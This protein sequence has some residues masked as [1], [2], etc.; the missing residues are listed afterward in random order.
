[1]ECY[2]GINI[3][4]MQDYIASNCFTFAYSKSQ[5]FRSNKPY[6]KLTL[7]VIGENNLM[8]TKHDYRSRAT[9]TKSVIICKHIYNKT[10]TS[11][12]TSILSLS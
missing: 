3:M 2:I 5:V 6:T 11:T 4:Q 7:D 8:Q 9:T 12:S 1:M 10:C